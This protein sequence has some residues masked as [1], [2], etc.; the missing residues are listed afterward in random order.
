MN[1]PPGKNR[2]DYGEE[3]LLLVKTLESKWAALE[4]EVQALHSYENPEIIAIPLV[5]VTKKYLD[6]M[7]AELQ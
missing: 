7:T 5:H 2:L 1:A 3:G 4:K 6:W